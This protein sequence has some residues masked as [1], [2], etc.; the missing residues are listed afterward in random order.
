MGFA[1][2]GKSHHR[3]PVEGVFKSDDAGPTRMSTGDLNR[4]LHRFSTAVH[5]QGFLGKLARCYFIHALGQAYV[6][7]IRR[8]LNTGVQKTIEL[9]ADRRQNRFLP[10]TD[11]DASDTASEINVAVSVNIFEPRIFRFRDINRGSVRE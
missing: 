4:V 11:V 8:D 2:E 6:V 7:F 9:L 10:V 5:E 1:G 3:A